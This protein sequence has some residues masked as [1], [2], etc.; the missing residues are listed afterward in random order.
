MPEPETVLRHAR[1]LMRREN[2]TAHAA[3]EL[4]L[5]SALNDSYPARRISV[6]GLPLEM[7]VSEA[8]TRCS[9][10]LDLAAR[11]TCEYLHL[12]HRLVGMLESRAGR[13][14][15]PLSW[16]V[17]LTLVLCDSDRLDVV[18]HLSPDGV[19]PLELVES[20]YA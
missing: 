11:K 4:A 6:K 1:T 13:G 17:V 2:A 7:L 16:R 12:S 8:M 3:L 10:D 18:D 19:I 14:D 20:M 9:D 5:S 15:A